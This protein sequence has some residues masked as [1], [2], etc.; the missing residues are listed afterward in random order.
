MRKLVCHHKIR[1]QSEGV[2]EQITSYEELHGGYVEQ[3]NMGKLK[4]A[5]NI[6]K[7]DLQGNV[8]TMWVDIYI[9]IYIYKNKDNNAIGLQIV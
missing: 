6:L 8:K 9:Y 4:N 2:R 5:Y 3:W 7:T 1:T